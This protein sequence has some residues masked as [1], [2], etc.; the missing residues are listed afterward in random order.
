MKTS[1]I[2]VFGCI[3]IFII[4]VISNLE[5]TKLKKDF[6]KYCVIQYDINS[7]CPCIGKKIQS[8]GLSI[9]EFNTMSQ[10][11]YTENNSS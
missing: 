6:D 1:N 7:Y 2:L 9:P 5:I 3:I 11:L 4:L 8:G 10:P